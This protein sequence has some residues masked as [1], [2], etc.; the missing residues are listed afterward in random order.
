MMAT[1]KLNTIRNPEFCIRLESGG[2]IRG[3]L[4][5]RFAPQTV[6]NF[7]ALA[8]GGFY[9]G[10]AF[11]RCIHDFI[12]QGGRAGEELGY[13]IRGEFEFNGYPNETLPHGYGC[14]SMS[15]GFDYNSACCEFFI[16][17]TENE[18]ELSCLD[19]AYAAFGR[20]T[21]GLE[22]AEGISLCA[23]DA[24]DEPLKR[25]GIASIRVEA[26]G[27]DYPFDRLE[28]PAPFTPAPRGIRR[29]KRRSDPTALN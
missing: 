28:P 4:Y 16:V 26:F 15:R 8:N 24:R 21:D 5:P 17:L 23:T 13:R 14:L 11:H 2:A 9:D 19:G 12:I 25:Q 10:N 20:V 29:G 6:G 1:G 22:L 18:R 7:I 27:Q 3:E